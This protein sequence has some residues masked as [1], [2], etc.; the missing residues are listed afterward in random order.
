M[1]RAWLTGLLLAAL[2]LGG[3]RSA[4]IVDLYVARDEDG[5]RRTSCVNANAEDFFVFIEFMSFRDDTL[6]WP[7]FG[8]EKEVDSVPDPPFTF[9]GEL[10]E[11]LAEFA[12]YAPGKGDGILKIEVLR[13]F[14]DGEP[15]PPPFPRG[16]FRMD[17]YLNDEGAPRD[18]ILWTVDDDEAKCPLSPIP[19]TY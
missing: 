14:K 5:V 16:V 8:V 9:G 17:V 4:H 19:D 6:I 15:P 11:Q 3:C 13:E 12:N 10:S 7:V 18:S 1:K 2:G